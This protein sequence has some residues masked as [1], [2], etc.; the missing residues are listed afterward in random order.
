[1]CLELKAIKMGRNLV[2]QKKAKN[3]K[4]IKLLI[5]EIHTLKSMNQSST[6][7]TKDGTISSITAGDNIGGEVLH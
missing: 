5:N 7:F 2:E 3:R 4:S 1:M 6:I